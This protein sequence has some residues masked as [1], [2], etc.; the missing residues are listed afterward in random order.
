M[1]L[2][3]WLI[4]A[5]GLT[6]LGSGRPL[7]P[8]DFVRGMFAD[9]RLTL[10][11]PAGTWVTLDGLGRFRAGEGHWSIEPGERVREAADLLDQLRG[12]PGAI[13]RCIHA[14]RAFQSDPSGEGRNALRRAYE[15]VPE[16]LRMYCGTWTRKIG[17]SGEP[18]A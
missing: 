7:V 1:R 14:Y 18:W 4:Y 11:A 10:S 17:R 16:H 6:Q 2:V 15:A 13:A 12:G 5:D 3:R 8:V 9:G